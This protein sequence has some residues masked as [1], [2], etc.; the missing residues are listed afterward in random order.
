M[1][2]H[3]KKGNGDVVPF[4]EDRVRANIRRTGASEETVQK[5][6]DA[7]LPKLE[8]GMSTFA[9]HNIVKAALQRE[10]T[11]HACRYN[12]RDGLLKLGPAGFNFEFY[13]AEL[14]RAH[15]YDAE[16]PT[17]EL[18]GACVEH[19]VDVVAHKDSRAMFIEAKFRNNKQDVVDLKSV[20]ATWSRF[21]DLVDGATLGYVE[22]FDECMIATNA[23]F[24]DAARKFGECKGV[25]FMGWDYP[26]NFSL[27]KLIDQKA[28]YPVT[29]VD[30]FKKHEVEALAES[31]LLLCQNLSEVEP[32][33]LSERIRVSLTRATEMIHLAGLVVHGE[34]RDASE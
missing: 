33:E 5:V 30:D 32:H 14:L 27:R 28:F 22:H 23:R 6:I 18:R 21:L 26:E 7:I 20:M 24:T 15:G 19:E 16:V 17:A 8:D 2:I 29:V 10:S 3:V 9:L 1:S 13:V 34:A 11:C 31:G 12:L 25:R 4:D